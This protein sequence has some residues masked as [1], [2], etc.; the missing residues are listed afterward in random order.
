MTTLTIAHTAENGTLLESTSRG[1]GSY[2]VMAE[3]RQSIG[4][5][6]WAPSLQQWIIVSSRDRQ[7]KDYYIDAAAKAL[8]AS[9]F[10]VELQ[11]DRT[12]R[13][14]AEAEAARAERQEDRVDALETKA[15]RRADKAVAADAA[16]RRAAGRVPPMGEPIKIGHHSEHRHRRSIEKAWD[17]LGRSVKA[18]DAADEAASRAAAA[19]RTTEH[20]HN[21][22]TV[23]NRIDTLEAEQ[24][25]DQRILDGGKRG[26]PPY[27][28]EDKPASGEYR[29]KVT[30]RMAQR[31]D[32]IEHWKAVRAKQIADGETLGLTKA[33]VAKGDA[34]K[35]R[36]DWY[37]VV[38]ANAKTVT[39]E[40]RYI[41]GHNG[42][43]PYQEIREHRK[44]AD[45][46]TTKA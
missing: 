6:R 12:H 19:A 27:V 34:V 18:H 17:A 42:T 46:T 3:L 16:S 38:R 9:G 44:A 36:G 24:R 30:A 13:S 32:D 4:H 41:A 23:A 29:E 1:D 11:I 14:A 5:W 21:P 7:P 2:E 22:V 15:D 43:V 26:R 39:V 31:A 45:L 20:R 35:V 28:Y 25:A 40:S 8:R 33:D 37:R 10:D